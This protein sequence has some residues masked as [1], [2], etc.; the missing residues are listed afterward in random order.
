MYKSING[1]NMNK[2]LLLFILCLGISRVVFSNEIFNYYERENFSGKYVL[3]NETDEIFSGFKYELKDNRI[4]GYYFSSN[5]IKFID[6][7]SEEKINST[8]YFNRSGEKIAEIQYFYDDDGKTKSIDFRINDT[9]KKIS[10]REKIFFSRAQENL[11]YF[12]EQQFEGKFSQTVISDG[13]FSFDY[14]PI[15]IRNKS[16]RMSNDIGIVDNFNEEYCYKNDGIHY[17]LFTG[18]QLQYEK[19]KYIDSM[20]EKS[21]NDEKELETEK[22]LNYKDNKLVQTLIHKDSAIKNEFNFQRICKKIKVQSEKDKSV[23]II[24]SLDEKISIIGDSIFSTLF[25]ENFFEENPYYY[26]YAGKQ[27]KL[28]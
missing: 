13:T 4:T 17:Q 2:K 14:F 24:T 12:S 6:K 3:S 11:K 5:I 23:T 28:K 19:I 16:I 25:I 10:Y 8:V 22:I 9:V 26:T 18:E 27:E 20:L 21:Y 15:L 1:E 7:I